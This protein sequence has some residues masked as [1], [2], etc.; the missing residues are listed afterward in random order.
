MKLTNFISILLIS[1]LLSAC[2][3]L[4]PATPTSTQV[5]VNALQTSVVQTV[6][7]NITQT[8]AAQPTQAPTD[9]PVPAAAGDRH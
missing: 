8:A 6:I 4:G 1:T 2:A 9:T 5:D 7:A 3:S